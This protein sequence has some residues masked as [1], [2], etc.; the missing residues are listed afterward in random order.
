M[1][2]FT[3]NNNLHGVTLADGLYVYFCI[4]LP[5]SIVGSLA[6]KSFPVGALK[7]N[8]VLELDVADLNKIVTT[9]EPGADEVGGH[10]AST[11]LT[12]TSIV[13][14]QVV[15]HAKV[16]N[17]GS[18]YNDV[19]MSSLG[20][21]FVIP[22][23]EYIANNTEVPANTSSM[24]ANFSFPVKSA[25][26]LLFWFTNTATAN[27]TITAGKLNSPITQRCFGGNLKEY[28]ISVNGQNY[29][30]QPI[31]TD[32]GSNLALN[33]YQGVNGSIPFQQLLRC[34][35][36]NSSSNSGGILSQVLYS[37]PVSTWAGDASCKRTVLGIDLDRGSNDNDKYYQGMNL[38]NTT[39][40]VRC[41]WNTAPTESQTMFS[42]MMH[43]CG[44]II[45]NGY[46][47]VSR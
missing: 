24:S 46:V 13:L 14:D 36:L 17:V 4:T 34:F 26:S 33:N 11:A 8:L 39:T 18:L 30:Q 6:E 43:D 29:P 32:A 31:K 10:T 19:L 1:I 28:Y 22:G 38:L 12:L 40:A 35:N 2:F 37:S 20:P 47:L 23:V 41:A 42:Y 9:R 5:M 7:T 3:M 15:Y 21:S 27:G 25:K 16:S 45:E 44:F